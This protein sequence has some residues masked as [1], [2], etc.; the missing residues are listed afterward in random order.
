MHAGPADFAFWPHRRESE[1]AVE[2]R[3]EADGIDQ[4]AAADADPAEQQAGN[5]RTDQHG[6]LEADSAERQPGG[7]LLV[8]QQPGCEGATGR[9][10]DGHETGLQCDE[11][12][13][14][15]HRG[16]SEEALQGQQNR[17]RELPDGGSQHQP[18]AIDAI[19][20]TAADQA[21]HDHRH[22]L[23]N[24]NGAGPDGAS[25][26]LPHLEH[27]RDDRHLAAEAGEGATDPQPPE[28][29]RCLQRRQVY[30]RA[31]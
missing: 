20:Q 23:R 21:D 15:H 3:P 5:R 4:I 31:R 26:E 17:H 29:R 25:G 16:V 7:H 24:A 22:G 9:S 10:A 14:A 11:G 8:R 19:R 18:A 12:K 2:G 30:Q 28:H 13:H 1:H 27:H 6:R